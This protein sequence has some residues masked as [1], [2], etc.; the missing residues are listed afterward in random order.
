M[1]LFFSFFQSDVHYASSYNF[2]AEYKQMIQE[3]KTELEL[4]EGEYRVEKR[5]LGGYKRSYFVLNK[6]TKISGQ[7]RGKTTL[8][9]F[10]LLIKGKKN[11]GIVEIEDLT[12]HGGPANGLQAYNGMKVRMRG[13]TVEESECCGVVADKADITCDDLQVLGCGQN[14]VWAYKNATITLSGQGTSIQRNGTSGSSNHHGLHDQFSSSKIQLCAPLTKEQISTN[15]GGGGNWGGYLKREQEKLGF[16][17]NNPWSQEK[18]DELKL[19]SDDEQVLTSACLALSLLCKSATRRKPSYTRKTIEQKTTIAQEKT[20]LLHELERMQLS[21]YNA[22]NLHRRK[23]TVQDPLADI[24]FELNR[25]RAKEQRKA[26]V[27]MGVVPR[28]VELLGHSNPKVQTPALRAIGNLVSG[29][30]TCT[31]AVIDANALPQLRVL[32]SVLSHQQET[33]WALSNVALGT[34]EQLQA[35]LDADVILMV[36]NLLTSED[37]DVKIK[38]EA[39][40]VLANIT[41]GTSAQIEMLLSKGVAEAL[42]AGLIV[43]GGEKAS[44]QGLENILKFGQTTQAEQ[45]LEENP[46]AQVIESVGGLDRLDA[47]QQHADYAIYNKAL[48]IL[49][50]YYGA[51]EPPQQSK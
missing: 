16:N 43:V 19:V 45:S 14:G 1:F 9:G 5:D 4:R 37:T 36:S 8:V 18:E 12:I 42:C 23:L 48:D 41:N 7:G 17:E 11:D 3:G 26:V 15:N 33:C 46:Q 2:I 29:D 24:E 34:T 21:G 13:C 32:L 20:V 40:D 27:G 44:M 30:A 22:W 50:L 49:E 35:V 28:L 39:V 31:Q 10:G 25:R 51:V 6:P 38:I 47:L